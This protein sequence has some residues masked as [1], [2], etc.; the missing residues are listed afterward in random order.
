MRKL[1]NI[2]I[3][4]FIPIIEAA[5]LICVVAHSLI[6][7]RSIFLDLNLS[8]K[9]QKLIDIVMILLGSF[10]IIYGIWLV[11]IIAQRNVI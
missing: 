10:S 3:N 2:T 7:M 8:G 4:I 9:V 6:G 11:I 1:L 5:F